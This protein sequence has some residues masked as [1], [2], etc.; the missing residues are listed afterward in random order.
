VHGGATEVAQCFLGAPTSAGSS[1]MVTEKLIACKNLLRIQLV[2]FLNKCFLLIIKSREILGITRAAGPPGAGTTTQLSPVDPSK[3]VD[4]STIMWQKEVESG[5]FAMVVKL[6][7][8]IAQVRHW[9]SCEGT[10]LSFSER[11]TSRGDSSS[12]LWS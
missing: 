9:T 2:D 1:Q 10:W 5:F 3:P 6:H 11:L 7:P 12:T 4:Q 8:M